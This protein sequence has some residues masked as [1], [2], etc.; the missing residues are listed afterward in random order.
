VVPM[1]PSERLNL[2]GKIKFQLAPGKTLRIQSLVETAKSKSYVHSYK[3][4]PDGTYNFRRTSISSNLQFTHTI[5]PSTF[6][7]LRG[8]YN[9]SDYK[10]FVYEDPTDSRYA[11]SDLIKGSPG[12]PT[13]VFSGTQMGHVYEKSESF[14]GKFDFTSQVNKNHLVKK[15]SL[16]FLVKRRLFFELNFLLAV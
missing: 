14:L 1:N 2:L 4:N 15:Q 9:T 7:E 12:S 6:Y 13:F 3:Y 8:G 10:Q 11:P 16:L 5:S